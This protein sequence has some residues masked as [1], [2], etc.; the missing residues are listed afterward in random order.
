MYVLNKF[1]EISFIITLKMGGKLD[2]TGAVGW[3]SCGMVEKRASS[4]RI[5]RAKTPPT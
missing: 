4:A 1:V 2:N 3:E 5:L